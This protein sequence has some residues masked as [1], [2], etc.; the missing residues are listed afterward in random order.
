MPPQCIRIEVHC[1]ICN[2]PI[3]LTPNEVERGLG[4]YCS[5]ACQGRAK[6]RPE[7]TCEHCGRQFWKPGNPRR[8]CGRRC[9]NL[10]RPT[11]PLDERFWSKVQKSESCWLWSGAQ[12]YGYGLLQR[13]ARDTEQLR[14]THVAWEL[15]SGHWPEPGEF[16][17]HTCDNPLCV[18]N[19]EGGTYE[20]NGV[21]YQRFGHLWLGDAA[22]N[23]A[24]RHAKGRES[25]GERHSAIQRSRA[26]RGE[27]SHHAKLT[28]AQVIA[29]R[30]ERASGVSVH[31]LAARY[32]VHWAHVYAICER[33][34]W[35]HLP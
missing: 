2:T 14:A 6:R 27:Q 33:R 10:A 20:V 34:A 11:R 8:F 19:D 22:A 5:R 12:K 7:Y 30:A 15:A 35:K 23:A 3:L 25:A 28:D 17:C 29:M 26:R 21:V 32:G 16:I 13:G 1:T 4:R 18:R 24:D 9:T 31:D